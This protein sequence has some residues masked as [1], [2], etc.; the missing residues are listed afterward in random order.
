MEAVFIVAIALA[1][2]CK[3]LKKIK[4]VFSTL[5]EKC[6]LLLGVHS[7]W[8]YFFSHQSPNLS[9]Y[10]YKS[11]DFK[12]NVPHRQWCTRLSLKVSRNFNWWVPA[13]SNAL[14][15]QMLH[16]EAPQN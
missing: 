14:L 8:S 11:F 2:L 16:N 15:P 13:C 3:T 1:M 9:F 4:N 12:K 7:K 10:T 6:L 5:L